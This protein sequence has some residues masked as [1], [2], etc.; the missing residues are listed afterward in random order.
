M[1]FS[2]NYDD[3]RLEDFSTTNLQPFPSSN[4]NLYKRSTEEFLRDLQL[5]DLDLGADPIPN[6]HSSSMQ[7]CSDPLGNLA[8]YCK[9]F[10]K[11]Y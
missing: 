2:E 1:D 6:N 9:K 3:I 7:S 8:N 10:I 11:S 5:G 4:T